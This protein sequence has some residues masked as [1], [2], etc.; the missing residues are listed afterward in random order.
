MHRAAL[1]LLVSLLTAWAA[2]AEQFDLV[3]MGEGV[4][5]PETGEQG[6][7]TLMDAVRKMS[8][9]PAQRLEA[10]TAAA[11]RKGRL[12]PG[13]DADIVVF[14]PQTIEDK[15]TYRAAGAPSVGVRYLLVA[16]TPVVAEGRI[17]DGV[18]PGRP[19]GSD[20]IGR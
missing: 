6:S 7:L 2:S 4:V 3:L 5:D 20:A 13:A 16:G 18:A 12:Q 11:R 10:V 9:M 8:L 15:A 1:A 14:D 17:V 19:L